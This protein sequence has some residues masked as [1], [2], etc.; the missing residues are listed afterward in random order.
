VPLK[1]ELCDLKTK[2]RL[3]QFQ[4]CICVEINFAMSSDGY[5]KVRVITAK[6]QCGC[7]VTRVDIYQ[8]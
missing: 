5:D 4:V 2:K 8:V 6:L 1:L 7:T 3:F